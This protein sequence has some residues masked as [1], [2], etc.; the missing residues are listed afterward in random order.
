MRDCNVVRVGPESFAAAA[1]AAAASF[2]ALL[3]QAICQ[4][5]TQEPQAT[6]D[7]LWTYAA[8]GCRAFFFAHAAAGSLAL[9]FGG[10]PCAEMRRRLA[11][12]GLVA[13]DGGWWSVR[14]ALWC[15][16][17][18]HCGTAPVGRL[19]SHEATLRAE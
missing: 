5:K 7:C 10:M 11:S 19:H 17:C 15:G 18:R 4:K 13:D 12:G 6:T 8:A 16:T 9:R 3:S 1:A 2:F 14:C